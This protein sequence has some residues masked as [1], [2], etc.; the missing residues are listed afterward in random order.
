MAKSLRE[1]RGLLLRRNEETLEAWYTLQTDP[2]LHFKS[3]ASCVLAPEEMVG[4]YCKLDAVFLMQP[5]LL[6]ANY[7][8]GRRERSVQHC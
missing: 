5:Q 3:T 1:K 4:P 7:R 2:A 6:M 8:C